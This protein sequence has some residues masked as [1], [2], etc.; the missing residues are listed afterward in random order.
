MNPADIH[1]LLVNAL[2]IAIFPA[3]VVNLLYI[4][5]LSGFFTE[6]EAKDQEAWEKLGRPE[7]GDQFSNSRSRRPPVIKT[8]GVLRQKA[9]RGG[10]PCAEKSMRWFIIA[11]IITALLLL[12][13]VLTIAWIE[14]YNL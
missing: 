14:I 7:A 13:G 12:L 10:Y 5:S 8:L 11:G 4:R 2:T 1:Q 6:L 3:A 9:S